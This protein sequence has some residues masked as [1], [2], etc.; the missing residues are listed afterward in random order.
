MEDNFPLLSKVGQSISK[1]EIDSNHDTA[2]REHIRYKRR[3]DDVL[4]ISYVWWELIFAVEFG[5]Y[6]V[7]VR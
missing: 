3:L 1:L 5:Y 6:L 7:I 4:F 2:G